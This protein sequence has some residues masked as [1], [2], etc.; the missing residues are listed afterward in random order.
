M[1]F[2]LPLPVSG[3]LL[4]YTVLIYL[5]VLSVNLGLAKPT[6]ILSFLEVRTACIASKQNL[7]DSVTYNIISGFCF[8]S[9]LSEFSLG[10]FFSARPGGDTTCSHVRQLFKHA[11]YH[12]QPRCVSGK[13]RRWLGAALSPYRTEQGQ[14]EMVSFDRKTFMPFS[15]LG[16]GIAQ[17]AQWEHNVQDPGFHSFP[18]RE[19]Y[20]SAGHDP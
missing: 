5:R 14:M 2:L 12:W 20:Y 19:T 13:E 15:E 1:A 6:S 18:A 11:R 3:L 8:S 17:I 16:F 10:V 7:T 9:S 4:G